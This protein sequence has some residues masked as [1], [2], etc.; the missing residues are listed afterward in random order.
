MVSMDDG[1]KTDAGHV[2]KNLIPY[3]LQVIHI[4]KNQG[5]RLLP[6]V[7]MVICRMFKGQERITGKLPIVPHSWLQPCLLCFK[8]HYITERS[9]R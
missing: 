4:L 7:S 3:N 6:S 5:N 1:E 2:L 9:V 8:H